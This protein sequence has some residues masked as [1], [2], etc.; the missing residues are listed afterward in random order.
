MCGGFV[1]GAAAALGGNTP[2]SRLECGSSGPT[3]PCASMRLDHWKNLLQQ[4]KKASDKEILGLT[5]PKT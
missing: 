4:C 2:F 1:P 5:V 3:H